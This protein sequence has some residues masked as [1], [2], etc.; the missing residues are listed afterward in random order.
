MNFPFIVNDHFHGH[1][2]LFNDDYNDLKI[3][4]YRCRLH[5]NPSR[6]MDWLSIL[7][8]I[9]SLYA[10]NSLFK[11]NIA[12]LPCLCYTF[13]LVLVKSFISIISFSLLQNN[14]N[15]LLGYLFSSFQDFIRENPTLVTS[16]IIIN[17]ISCL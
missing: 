8:W 16:L 7:K 12:F 15:L 5:L 10:F 17:L 13:T 4:I 3:S 11:T 1:F 2:R 6:L 14:L 9:S